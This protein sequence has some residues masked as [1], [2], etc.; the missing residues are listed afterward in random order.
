MQPAYSTSEGHR[1]F[2][3]G[4][5]AMRFHTFPRLGSCAAE[6]ALYGRV[7]GARPSMG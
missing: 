5:K 7:L 4:Q 6:E 2:V 3:C 1:F